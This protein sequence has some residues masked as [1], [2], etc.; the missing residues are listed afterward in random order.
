MKLS[1][2][3]SDAIRKEGGGT[4]KIGWHHRNKEMEEATSQFMKSP[5]IL[6]RRAPK[7]NEGKLSLESLCVRASVNKCISVLK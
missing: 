4:E 7:F 1:E 2:M 6:M 3:T 5:I